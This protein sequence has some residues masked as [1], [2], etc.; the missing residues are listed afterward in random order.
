LGK[1]LLAISWPPLIGIHQETPASSEKV[2]MPAP[3][4]NIAIAL[5]FSG[6]DDKLLAE[7]L[8]FLHKGKTR[9]TLLHV[10]ES[11]VARAL[12]VE[13]E[14]F[15]IQSDQARLEN[16]ADQMK[17]VGFKAEWFLGMG[18]PV[19]ELARMINVTKADLVIVG[20]HGHTGMSDLIHGT[21][22]NNLR[23]QIQASLLV[24]PLGSD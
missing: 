9:L 6:N 4:E 14:D 3:H 24:V 7:S 19:S 5:D 15:E 10:V 17:N 20:S 21:V 1:R 8:R 23:H 11:P 18:N 13:G 16:L 2:V 22:I 12:G